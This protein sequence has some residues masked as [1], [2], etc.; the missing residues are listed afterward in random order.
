MD[1]LQLQQAKQNL[2]GGNYEAATRDVNQILGRSPHNFF[3]KRLL[4]KIESQL[5]EKVKEDIEA[6]QYMAAIKKTEVLLNDV[7]SEREEVKQLQNEAKKYLL[8]QAAQN[9]LE[10]DSPG[11]ALTQT[12]EA[13]E[14][15]PQFQ[16]ALDVRDEAQKRM[17]E[18]IANLMNIA[19]D[20]I[21][22]K[23]F[24]E[25]QKQASDILAQDPQNQEATKL[26]H[27][28]TAQLLAMEKEKNL[29]MAR[30]F[31]E[32]GVY[33]SAKARAER[34][35]KVDPNSVEAKQLLQKAIAE[36]RKPPVRLRAFTTIKGMDIAHMELPKTQER[37]M[38]KEGDT[39]GPFKV[40]AIDLDLK[41]VV[42]TYLKTGSQQTLSIRE[43]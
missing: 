41:A 16:E 30:E 28:A 14:L 20:L 5:I 6:E 2:E 27:E 26:L 18:K 8:V 39:F 43:E 24:K 34:V 40:S 4:K 17:D 13:L 37:F 31:F 38:V 19:Q 1:K 7:H 36:I 35:L 23:K 9:S 12:A 42:V 3:A 22:Q 29:Q 32:Q 33:E 25:L 21:A 10:S 15:D 11:K